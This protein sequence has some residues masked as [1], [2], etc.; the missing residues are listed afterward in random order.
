MVMQEWT[1]ASPQTIDIDAPV[2]E[3][4]IRIVAGHVDVVT[5]DDPD[6]VRVEVT[7]IEDAPLLVSVDDGVLTIQHERVTWDGILGWLR[8]DRKLERRRAVVSV[9][10][11]P[12]CSAHIGVVSASAVLAGLSGQTRV[13]CV[14]GDVVLD[15]VAGEI[16]VESV[17]GDIEA[18]GLN[19]GLSLRTVSGGLTVVDGRSGQVRA[20]SV[21]GDVALDLQP[22]R[23]VDI[24]VTTVSGDVTV[25]LPGE[26]G[27]TV[28]LASTSGDLACAF[29]GLNLQKRPGSRRLSGS[30]GDGAGALHGRT[31]SGRVA[32]LA[33]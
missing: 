14:S 24:D 7:D 12:D 33:R 25:R 1:V 4:A 8:L 26:T 2:T 21:S 32:L 31:V 6:G 19:G 27:A 5:A 30:I 16:D 17:S 11:P 9:A 10:V 18:R 15:E 13:R 23:S 28:D 20:K 29:D 3:L 22:E